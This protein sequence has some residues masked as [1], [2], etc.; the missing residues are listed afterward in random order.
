[1]R[2]EN[3]EE[4]KLWT[5]LVREGWAWGYQQAD[6]IFEQDLSRLTADFMGMVRYRLLL[7]KGQISPP[8][9][10]HVDRGVT[11][12]GAEMRIGDRAV[13]ITGVPQLLTGSQEWHPE[14]R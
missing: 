4:R 3:E 6:E 9:A 7:S 5:D 10:L 1:M 13:Q 11:G 12:G 2:P 14:S 8:Y